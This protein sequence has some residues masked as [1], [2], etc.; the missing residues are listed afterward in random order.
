MDDVTQW[1]W[2]VVY[3]RSRFCVMS[4]RSLPD[5]NQPANFNYTLVL[6]HLLG[7]LEININGNTE[8]KA[9]T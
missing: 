2:Q 5:K 4:K 3:V 9:T 8:D 1:M 6:S 7:H